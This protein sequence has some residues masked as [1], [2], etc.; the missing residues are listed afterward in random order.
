MQVLPRL[1]LVPKI[2]KFQCTNLKKSEKTSFSSL[3]KRITGGLQG[4]K[5]FSNWP[6]IPQLYVKGE[7]IGGCDIITEMAMS[8]ELDDL[9]TEKRIKF[10]SESA[11]K[12]REANKD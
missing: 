11:N 6:T 7:F 10:N 2:R 4:I 3:F 5:N 1:T 8:G 12:I 9:F